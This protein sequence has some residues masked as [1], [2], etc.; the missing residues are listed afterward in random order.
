MN[1]EAACL[2][3]AAEAAPQE[4]R[5][6]LDS[7]Q[8]GEQIESVMTPE[9]VYALMCAEVKTQ[10]ELQ[11]YFEIWVTKYEGNSVRD[12]SYVVGAGQ[13]LLL[14]SARKA[15][16][17]LDSSMTS[18]PYLMVSI[19]RLQQGNK[20]MEARMFREI[21]NTAS[22]PEELQ[23]AFDA[24]LDAYT[25]NGKHPSHIDGSLVGGLPGVQ[26]SVVEL[27]Q[28]IATGEVAHVH[29]EALRDAI[30]RVNGNA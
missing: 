15:I 25:E 26:L 9:E 30:V 8:A 10:E 6:V 29:S 22:N 4:W 5:A 28:A 16:A 11:E 7:H 24:L 13:E 27:Q 19:E 1:P 20:E 12:K 17:T 21:M 14:E 2:D 3:S 18:D 23:R